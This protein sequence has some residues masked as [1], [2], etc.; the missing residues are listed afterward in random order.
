MIVWRTTT[1]VRRSNTHVLDVYMGQSHLYCMWIWIKHTYPA[2]VTVNIGTHVYQEEGGEKVSSNP[3]H[4]K[5]L[6]IDEHN[7]KC[8]IETH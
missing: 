6:S 3:N 4:S 5:E 8:D 2:C 1:Y 7:T